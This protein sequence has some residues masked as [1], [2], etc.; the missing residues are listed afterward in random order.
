MSLS[1]FNYTKSG[2]ERSNKL[3]WRIGIDK[4]IVQEIAK[5]LINWEEHDAKK[6]SKRDKQNVNIC[7]WNNEHVAKQLSKRDEQKVKNCLC[8]NERNPTTVSE[9]MAQIQDLQN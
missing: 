1:D 6:L 4:K 8:N 5:K 3:V 7:L 2:S 9:I